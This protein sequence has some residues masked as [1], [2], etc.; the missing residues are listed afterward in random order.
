MGGVPQR[1]PLEL[2][3][4][5][6]QRERCVQQQ[7][8]RERERRA[9]A[10]P[11]SAV[12]SATTT[13]SNAF[14]GGSTGTSSFSPFSP[15]PNQLPQQQQHQ[16]QQ[17]QQAARRGRAVR[18]GGD[19]WEAAGL[20]CEA[21]VRAGAATPEQG[22]DQGR[23]VRYAEGMGVGEVAALRGA[24]RRFQVNRYQRHAQPISRPNSGS[25]RRGGGEFELDAMHDLNGT[26]AS[27]DLDQR[28]ER[29]VGGWGLLK[30]PTATEASVG[31]ESS[32]S[33]TSGTSRSGSGEWREQWGSVQFRMSMESP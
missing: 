29:G 16:G 2:L 22:R 4:E 12:W 21:A 19:V 33:G 23:G 9:A 17:Q 3:A 31:G 5:Q 20:V 10:L 28:E 27:L 6:Q 32:A 8:E 30:S 7:R 24:S 26:L 15:D 25:A 14:V 1:I 11:D 13:G 18:G